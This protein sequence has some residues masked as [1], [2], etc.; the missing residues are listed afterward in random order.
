M[1]INWNDL[2]GQGWTI[3][4]HSSLEFGQSEFH[5]A[6]VGETKKQ[7]F[8]TDHIQ[9]LSGG[10]TEVICFL[11]QMKNTI[12]EEMRLPIQSWEAHWASYE[13]GGGYAPHVDQ[14]KGRSERL[15]SLVGYFNKDWCAGD[16]GELCIHQGENK[17]T[18]APKHGTWV[19]FDS[20]SIVHEV[21]P[22]QVL[23][24]SLACWFRR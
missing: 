11:D 7:A 3:F 14:I 1:H 22:T 19:L 8:R 2:I 6:G 4:E 17:I 18:I 12:R 23:R 21:L 16:G 20:N 9:W 10:E 5:K 24:R 15:L 13:R